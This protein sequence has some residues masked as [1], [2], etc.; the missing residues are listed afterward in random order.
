MSGTLSALAELDGLADAGTLTLAEIAALNGAVDERECVAGDKRGTRT[1]YTKR[2][3]RC[4]EC[5]CANR[6]YDRQYREAN[7]EAVR[8]QKR[9]NREANREAIRERNRRHYEAN[10]EDVLERQRR[11]REANPDAVR[12]KYRQWVEANTDAV[13]EGQRRYREA[14]REAERERKR[15]YDK[16]NP[17]KVRER[18][19]T[20][21]A[22]KR[23]AFVETV[24]PRQVFERDNWICHICNK[25]IN[26]KAVAPQWDSASIDH[27]IALAR[28]RANGGVHSYANCKA[29]HLR[30]NIRK[31]AR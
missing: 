11:Y 1:G 23:D 21:R 3:C 22:R 4:D 8:E 28:G 12:E 15:Q 24:V 31:G 19:H 13:R 29:A 7:R 25:K 9:Q 27:V 26:R 6:E 30:C 17:D 2:K 20:R 16:A 18:W 10:R 5:R 14:N